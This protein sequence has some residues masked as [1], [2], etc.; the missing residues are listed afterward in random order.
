MPGEAR[1]GE[2]FEPEAGVFVARVPSMLD[3][4]A[5][6][7][8]TD[9]EGLRT[10]WLAQPAN[11]SS[12]LVYAGAGMWLLWRRRRA[13][14]VAGGPVAG[15]IG[16]MAVGA[17]SFAYH[18]PQ[19]GW[20]AVGHDGAIAGLGLV[21]AASGVAVVRQSTSLRRGL[22]RLVVAWGWAAA[23]MV[24]ASAAY[25]AGRTG[26]PLCDPVRLWQPHAAWHVLSALALAAA[27]AGSA[28][29]AQRTSRTP[30][31]PASR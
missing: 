19:P 30:S 16:L 9:C 21:L 29:L 11:A 15:A 6:L 3:V 8:G 13:G 4:L 14:A 31:M 12:S 28:P 25:L 27:F 1:S 17:G 24:P 5:A 10:G 7:G 18:G 22:G 23:W 20:A 2:A 26:A